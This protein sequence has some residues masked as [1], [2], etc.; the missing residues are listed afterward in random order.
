[1]PAVMTGVP[2]ELSELPNSVH[3]ESVGDTLGSPHRRQ[4]YKEPNDQLDA[5]A[6]RSDMLPRTPVPA[7]ESHGSM[8][9]HI[10]LREMVLGDEDRVPENVSKGQIN[11][12]A[13]MLS[14]LRR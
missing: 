11:A 12:L 10:N 3:K 9:S 1:M 8:G 14:A 7:S 2:W 13:K 5:I 4:M 6:E